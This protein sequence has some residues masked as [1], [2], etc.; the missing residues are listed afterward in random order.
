MRDFLIEDRTIKI[1]R[2]GLIITRTIV[3]MAVN[4]IRVGHIITEVKTIA[5][6]S[7]V[8]NCFIEVKTKPPNCRE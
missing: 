1:I 2:L 3:D 5:M 8:I 6:D 7:I 4:I